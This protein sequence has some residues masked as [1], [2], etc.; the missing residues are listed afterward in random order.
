MMAATTQVILMDMIPFMTVLSIAMLG[1]TIFFAIHQ[2]RSDSIHD[3]SS[4]LVTVYQMTL[5]IGQGID[6]SNESTM[7]VAVVTAFTSFVVVV[8]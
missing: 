2:S 4:T 7:T 3:L 8:L 5:G 6:T 1:N